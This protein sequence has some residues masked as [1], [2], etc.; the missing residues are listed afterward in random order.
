LGS[1]DP[2]SGINLSQFQIQGSK[3]HR[4][5]DPDPQY[6]IWRDAKWNIS[7]LWVWTCS[8]S[9]AHAS[10]EQKREGYFTNWLTV[11]S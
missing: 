10:P 8:A 11:K 9:P 2:R 7:G 6:W 3:K 1:W 4:I 5:P